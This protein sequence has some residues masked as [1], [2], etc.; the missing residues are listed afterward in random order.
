MSEAFGRDTQ[1]AEPK[2]TAIFLTISLPLRAL[3]GRN[4]SEIGAMFAAHKIAILS[5]TF[6]P[7]A[8]QFLQKK[9]IAPETELKVSFQ[10]RRNLQYAVNFGKILV[11]FQILQ[12][13][14]RGM[15]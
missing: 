9:S 10:L 3:Q 5:A 15:Q 4:G 14:E 13:G 7:L 1:K 11:Q 12:F 8:L 6:K 2:T